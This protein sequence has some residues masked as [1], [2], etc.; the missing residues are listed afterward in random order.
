M[1]QRKKCSRQDQASVKWE[2][3]ILDQ[4]LEQ[5]AKPGTPQIPSAFGEKLSRK[6][7]FSSRVGYNEHHS[8]SSEEQQDWLTPGLNIREL[9]KEN[10]AYTRPE[11]LL[12]RN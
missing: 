12:Y 8:F 3:V 7:F 10:T 1:V 5:G 2:T 4:C 6:Q 9:D 11:S